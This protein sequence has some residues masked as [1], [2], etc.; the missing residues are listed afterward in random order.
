MS[1]YKVV[2]HPNYIICYIRYIR[3]D[4]YV[5]SDYRDLSFDVLAMVATYVTI[6]AIILLPPF[7]LR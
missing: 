5:L 1:V 2:R 6:L 4:R 7:L 3:R